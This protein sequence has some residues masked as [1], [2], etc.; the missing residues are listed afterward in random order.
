MKSW[1]LWIVTGAL[2]ILGGG[3]ALLNPLAAT[4]TAEQIAAWVFLFAGLL[5]LF[6]LFRG[7]GWSDRLWALILAL[8]CLWL[9][10]S[11]LANPLAGMIALTLVVA[12][13]LMVSGVAKLLLAMHTRKT[14]LFWPILVSGGASLV[15][16]AMVFLNLPQS[17]A[18]LLGV[19][20]A[21]ELILSGAT[22][23]A[24]A[25]RMRTLASG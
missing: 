1:I 22:I 16:A 8:A 3:I 23:V 13:G 15:L 7:Q 19:M 5:Q 6:A 11:L 2:M 17:A 21:A 18:V 12:S 9:G 4:L 10:A 14:P 24:F 25:L 20:L